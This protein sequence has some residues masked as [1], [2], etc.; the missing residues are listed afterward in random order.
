MKKFLLFLIIL[1]TF[2]GLSFAAN[3]KVSFSPLAGY[4][5][6][7]IDI[8]ISTELKGAKIYYTTDGSEPTKDSIQYSG[9]IMLEKTTAI[10][11]ISMTNTGKTE[12][13]SST[14][15]IDKDIKSKYPNIGVVSITTAKAN[16]F[17]ENK[18]IYVHPFERG[19]EWRRPAYLEMFDPLGKR[20]VAQPIEIAMS[21]NATRGAEKKSFRAI[22][23]NS[24][25]YDI[26]DGVVL[27]DK[28]KPL[29]KYK[30]FTLRNG[31]NDND[32]TM[33]MDAF[34]QSFAR[35]LKVDVQG[36]RPSI[37]FINGE[38]WGIYN[39]RERYDDNY[40]ENHYGIDKNNITLLEA[41]NEN[42]D[43]VVSEGEPQDVKAYNDM[44]SFIT[45]HDMSVEDNYIAASKLIDIDNFI[46]YH[47]VET[48]IAN[49]DWPQNNI[50][51]WRN[52]NDKDPS[53]FD[54]KWR[55]VMMDTE[56]GW[57]F[58]ESY[59]N[60][61]PDPSWAT[62]SR[63]VNTRDNVTDFY[64]AMDYCT[65]LLRS[66]LKN[67]SFKNKFINRYQELLKTEFSKPV[68]KERLDSMSKRIQPL[69]KENAQ[70]WGLTYASWES[71][72]K[73]WR[74]F[75]EL[76]TTY[77]KI[78]LGT[79]FD[80]PYFR[81]ITDWEKGSVSING[82]EINAENDNAGFDADKIV[83]T[84]T[85]KEGNKV[86]T[87]ILRNIVTNER[88]YF[89]GNT[90]TLDKSSSGEIE[91]LFAKDL[92][93]NFKVCA[94]YSHVLLQN[95]NGDIFGWG[96]NTWGQVGAVF[97][98]LATRLPDRDNFL[99]TQ[100]LTSPTYIASGI[101]DISAGDTHSLMLSS[102]GSVYARGSNINNQQGITGLKDVKA[103]SAGS[104]LSLALTNDGDLYGAGYSPYIF[105]ESGAGEYKK[106][107]SNVS[108]M[109][110][111]K[112]Y[113]LYISG[114]KLYSIGK[115]NF[116]NGDNTI[117]IGSGTEPELIM[118]NVAFCQANDSNCIAIT[119]KGELFGWGRNSNKQLCVEESPVVK[120]VL[121]SSGVDMAAISATNLL[122]IKDDVLYGSGDNS[123]GQLNGEIKQDKQ[124]KLL[125][126]M[127]EVST[128]ATGN[129]FC[130]IKK[131]NGDIITIGRNDYGMQ[132]NGKR[133]H[134]GRDEQGNAFIGDVK[135]TN[136][137]INTII[138]M[139]DVI[140]KIEGDSLH[141]TNYGKSN[142]KVYIYLSATYKNGKSGGTSL[143]T[144]DMDGFSKIVTLDDFAG[145]DLKSISG[146][147]WTDINKTPKW[148]NTISK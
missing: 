131:I 47:I 84:A 30:S 73:R 36:Y 18:G 74:E 123:F 56:L 24:I 87:I 81:V 42:P 122:V 97:S 146:Y 77:S 79:C 35:N 78:D 14:Y 61:A 111:G 1:I 51:V 103:I 38:Y 32:R 129:G 93:T 58:W 4:Y 132:G 11:A 72:M 115:M 6:S 145:M 71:Y 91:V 89:S 2:R 57:G 7:S 127:D 94:Q 92:T 147:Y 69:V 134:L 83:V 135:V 54:T 90:A 106:L 110:A 128:A 27:D 99:E 46:D 29:E 13:F 138:K 16:L 43:Y 133:V 104:N 100:G 3:E 95:E 96:S 39:I 28:G 5:T 62:L 105:G 25:K 53:G 108:S 136:V 80:I 101:M 8:K 75:A 22:G 139:G 85:P 37:L 33:F 121:V 88:Q 49:Y 140:A 44:Y 63:I 144:V 20:T 119:T 124:K 50:K 102:D 19:K 114:G 55:W 141:L 9:A 126:L 112:G 82:Q 120:P 59:F 34:L 116:R 40:F 10:R 45:K 70:R 86:K 65:G 76:R 48:F 15:F 31:G 64:P 23:N 143:V 113:L 117:S 52:K 148:I 17:D 66:L 98:G 142:Q 12:I 118:E 125:Y 130:V 67:G 137:D 68:V 109:S 26:F 21:G 107:A 60:S 41:V